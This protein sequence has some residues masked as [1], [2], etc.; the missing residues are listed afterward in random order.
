MFGFENHC[1]SSGPPWFWITVHT[2]CGGTLTCGDDDITH[3]IGVWSE[4]LSVCGS[5]RS[6]HSLGNATS[7]P[8]HG[9]TSSCGEQKSSRDVC[10]D[11]TNPCPTCTEQQDNDPTE[12]TNRQA[13][14]SK[15]P[16]SPREIMKPQPHKQTKEVGHQAP[17]TTDHKRQRESQGNR[18]TWK[19]KPMRPTRK[20][21]GQ[22]VLWREKENDKRWTLKREV[23]HQNLWAVTKSQLERRTIKQQISKYLP[24]YKTPMSIRMEE[25]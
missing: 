11:I 8:S 22:V 16:P 4:L 19:G 9:P 24:K 6:S 17:R 25:M 7:T 21:V 15:R 2:T 5:R 14:K 13:K 18:W 23:N 12:N 10:A 20:T 1:Y 3:M